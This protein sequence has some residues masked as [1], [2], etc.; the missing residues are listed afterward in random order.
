[1]TSEEARMRMEHL[2]NLINDHNYRYYVLDT[3]I[4][5]D[6]DFDMLLEELA[7]LE[8]KYPQFILPDT[9]TQRVGGIVTRNFTQVVHRYPMLS[10]SNSY[11]KNEIDEFDLRIRK[12]TGAEK[13]E[14]TCEL[15]FDGVAISLL[16]ENGLLTRAITRGDGVQGDDVTV[17]V[18]TIRSI[19]LRIRSKDVPGVFEVRGEIILPHKS[20]EKINREKEEAGEPPFAN[21]RN[22]ASGSLKLQ[23]SK[24]VAARRLECF[25]YQIYSESITGKTHYENL[26][27]L[28]TWGFMTSPYIAKCNG[29]EEIF[30][31][32]DYWDSARYELPFDIDGI[33]VK[34]NSVS[35]Q[36]VLGSTAKSPRWAIA[37]K[38]KAERVPTRLLSIG[39]QV[40]RTGA[41]TPVANL[42]PVLLAGTVVKRASLHNADIIAGMDVRPGDIVF[43]EKGGEIIPKIVGVDLDCRPTDSIPFQ[44]ITHCPECNTP[45]IRQEGES[46]YFCPNEDHCPPQ[47][48]GKL[49][50][51]ISRKAMNIESLGEGKIELLFEKNLVRRIDDF[52]HLTY[53]KLFGL[54]KVIYSEEGEKTRQISFREKTVNNILDGIEKSKSVPFHKVLF[55]LGIRHVGET[56]AKKIAAY[57]GSIDKIIDASEEELTGIADVGEKIARSIRTYFSRDE[58]LMMVENLRKAGVQ[59]EGEVLGISENRLLS[60]KSLVV[61]GVFTRFERD[62]LKSLIEKNGGK[63]VSSVSAKTDYIVAGENM[64]PSKLEKARSLNIRILSEDEFLALLDSQ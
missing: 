52:Y 45:L 32:I 62:E 3:P 57:Y 56:V 19:P 60:G 13:E 9:P 46:A 48:K 26:T 51:F 55:A 36:D 16:Y 38:F 14:Y 24:E 31:F 44:F 28:K 40:G 43:V 2:T 22:A 6:Y 15:K 11:S 37:Y 58:H 47:I 4:V 27:L 20:F 30:E 1:M 49:E 17:N 63:V 53:E 41:I 18:K 7:G 50:H 12:I 29:V 61:S 33:V 35:K 42:D 34:L 21:P 64:G 25:L 54:E 39:F 8:K 10:L 59:L 5:S 23:N